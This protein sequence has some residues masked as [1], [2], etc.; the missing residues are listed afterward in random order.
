MEILQLPLKKEWFDMILAGIKKEEYRSIKKHWAKRFLCHIGLSPQFFGVNFSR[1]ETDG[2][3][4]KMEIPA[5]YFKKYDVI[6]F[7][8]GYG[9]QVPTMVIECK[10]IKAGQAQPEWS[11]NWQGEVFVISL[12]NILSS[13]NLKPDQVT[14]N[15]KRI[16]TL[17][18]IL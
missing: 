10:G 11:N 13:R 12:G 5:G 7:T 6:I 3:T 18:S 8:N 1:F 2:K 15:K 14:I 9:H 17:K 16:L 4:P